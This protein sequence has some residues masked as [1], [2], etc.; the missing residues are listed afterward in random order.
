LDVWVAEWHRGKLK[1]LVRIIQSMNIGHSVVLQR[2]ISRL[3]WRG[4]VRCRGN[5]RIMLLDFT[6]FTRTRFEGLNPTK[7][8]GWS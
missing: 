5:G 8:S 6:D 4:K 3:R 2:G 7:L 1:G